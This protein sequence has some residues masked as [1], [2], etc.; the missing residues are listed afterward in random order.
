MFRLVADE[1]IQADLKVIKQQL[2]MLDARANGEHS[3]HR[4]VLL[5]NKDSVQ[6]K[7]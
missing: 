4:A 3:A 6:V 7:E 1:Y 5:D 2:Q